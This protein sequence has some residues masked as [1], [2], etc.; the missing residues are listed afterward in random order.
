MYALLVT[1]MSISELVIMLGIA[2]PLIA[3]SLT[4]LSLFGLIGLLESVA[5]GNAGAARAADPC[6]AHVFMAS[7]SSSTSI[8][9]TAGTAGT[10]AEGT[11][12]CAPTTDSI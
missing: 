2:L 6:F 9:G 1:G 10:A 4:A 7:V 3:L 8:D 11:G 12:C 5:V